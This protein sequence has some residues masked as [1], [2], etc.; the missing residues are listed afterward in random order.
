MPLI[1]LPHEC[2]NLVTR[3][4]KAAMLLVPDLRE[5]HAH[6]ARTAAATGGFHLDVLDHFQAH[7]ELASR[8][9]VFGINDLLELV[10]SHRDHPLLVVS[11]LEFLLAIWLSQGD[12]RQV[13]RDLSR[14][15]ELWE[16]TPAF[17]LVTGHD[18]V[19]ATYQPERHT[20]GHLVM[21][22]SHTAALS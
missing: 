10:A 1:D 22:L 16:R 4:N 15:I 6:A 21:E 19:L 11:G 14:R 7:P 5:Q 20:G 17:L 13:K 12:A 8:I 2:R 18:P 9:A 3:R